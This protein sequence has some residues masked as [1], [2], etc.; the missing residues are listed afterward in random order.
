VVVARNVCCRVCLHKVSSCDWNMLDIIFLRE[1]LY[2]AL[3]SMQNVKSLC[4]D[5]L[6]FEF[7][8][9]MSDTIGDDFCCLAF[10]VFASC[11]LSK[12]LN[13]G[14]VKLIPK[15]VAID[16]IGGGW[17]VTLL[18]VVSKIM[19]KVLALRIHSVAR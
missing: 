5:G 11:H 4:M 3:T 16:S 12:F 19:A 6:P 13:M 10:E 1:E 14:L 17:S 2:V 18:I 8:E 15:N 7:F 9:A